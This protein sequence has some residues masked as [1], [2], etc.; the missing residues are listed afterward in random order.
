MDGGGKAVSDTVSALR[1]AKRI[2]VVGT[3]GTGKTT[4]SR[5]LAAVLGLPCEELDRLYWR[6]GW[7]AAPD[8]DFLAAVERAVAEECWVLDGNYNKT[9]HIKWAAVECVVWLDYSFARVL[10]QAVSRAWRRSVTKEEIWPGTGNRE[11]FRK[12]FISRDSIILWTLKTYSS[13]RAR[14]L[15]LMADGPRQGFAVVRIES[16]AEA[17][18]GLR[19]LAERLPDF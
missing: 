9:A 3:S 19:A 15:E 11:S 17:E 6:P 8:E 10:F 4:F 13:N 14:Y 2:N 1:R 7:E 5:Q 16:A 18:E 12:S